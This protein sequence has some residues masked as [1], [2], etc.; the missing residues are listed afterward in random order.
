MKLSL[1]EYDKVNALIPGLFQ[2]DEKEMFTQAALAITE[3]ELYFYDDN[4]PK[5]IMGEIY[6][7]PILKRV[8]LDNIVMA[9]D[10]KITGNKQLNTMA[11][12]NF[13]MEEEDENLYFYYYLNDK[14]DVDAF[15]KELAACGIKTK[16]RKV[17]L[18]PENI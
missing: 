7:Y 3:N 15:I 18:S 6:H 5:Q 16:K 10:E 2:F 8:K 13:I 4:A 14:R 1:D 12:L 17:D 11:R 9:L